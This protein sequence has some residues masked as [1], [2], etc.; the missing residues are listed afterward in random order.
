MEAAQVLIRVLIAATA[1][2]VIAAGFVVLRM[3]PESLVP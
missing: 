2:V 1:L 3:E